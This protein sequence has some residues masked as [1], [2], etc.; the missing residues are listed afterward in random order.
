MDHSEKVDK[1]ISTVLKLAKMD[2][3]LAEI[4]D[5]AT[6]VDGCVKK[7]DLHAAVAAAFLNIDVEPDQLQFSRNDDRAWAGYDAV[8]QTVGCAASTSAGGG[9]APST[10]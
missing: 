3:V 1:G 4:K 2:T 10:D 7:Q 8:Y 5:Q 9:W 6:V